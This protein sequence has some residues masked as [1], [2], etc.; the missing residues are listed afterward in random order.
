MNDTI[1]KMSPRLLRSTISNLSS[2]TPIST[3]PAPHSRRSPRREP[4]IQPSTPSTLHTTV[5]EVCTTL[6]PSID[7]DHATP[8][9]W[10]TPR[11]VAKV[12]QPNVASAK[13]GTPTRPPCRP[14][15]P[16]PARGPPF[17]STYLNQE[18][19]S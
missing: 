17:F 9:Q 5:S 4:K 19:S 16:P 10:C 13:S 1:P 11:S 12:I 14:A 18:R 8:P 15:D 3:A 6:S 2:T 7:G